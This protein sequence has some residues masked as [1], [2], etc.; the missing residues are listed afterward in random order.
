LYYLQKLVLDST[1][2][3]LS[4]SRR[5]QKQK[6]VG[7]RPLL[8]LYSK[9]GNPINIALISCIR[10]GKTAK[11]LI[12]RKSLGYNQERYATPISDG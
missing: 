5:L 9:K 8:K 3:G 4:E 2:Q 1:D 7:Y 6:Y 11:T 10:I 12:Y